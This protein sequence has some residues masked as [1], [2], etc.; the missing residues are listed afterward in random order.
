MPQ[1]K[2]GKIEPSSCTVGRQDFG[3]K[4]TVICNKGFK[5]KGPSEKRCDGEHGTWDSK[6]EE[7]TCVDEEP[8]RLEC[9]KDINITSIPGNKFGYVTWQVPNITGY[10]K[11]LY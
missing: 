1:I 3:K 4:C 6:Y 8:P 11:K 10:F 9:P 2:Y 5:I 7:T